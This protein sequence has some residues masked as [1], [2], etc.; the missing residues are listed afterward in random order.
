MVSATVVITA[1]TTAETVKEAFAARL[2]EYLAGVIQAKYGTVY[3][4]PEEDT[5]LHR[6]LQPDS[7]PAA[8]H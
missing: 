2:K 3:Y 1:A 6:H 7:R 4:G 8:D 5:G